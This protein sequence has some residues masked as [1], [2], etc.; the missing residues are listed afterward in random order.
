MVGL[1]LWTAATNVPTVHSPGDIWALRTMVEGYR[2]EKTPHSS[3]R[4]LWQF[5]QQ[6]H[7]VAKQ[8]E[9]A[10]EMMNLAYEIFLS[11]FEGFFNIS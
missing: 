2:Q 10:Y 9:L 4:A 6:G 3:T 8:K 1:R 11:Y 7:L 5:F